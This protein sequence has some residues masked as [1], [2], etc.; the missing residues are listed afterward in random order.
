[1]EWLEVDYATPVVPAMVQVYET[2]HPGA[3]VCVTVFGPDGAEV[4]AWL[5][6]DP[7]PATTA[8]GVSTVPLAV[9]FKISRVRL[10]LD[11]SKVPG[12]NEVD[13]VGL[14]DQAG[15]LQWAC[16]ARASSTYASNLSGGHPSSASS[17]ANPASSQTLVPPWGDFAI[18]N[19]SNFA[20][21]PETNRSAEAHGWPVLAF[22]GER[23][24]SA[25][26]PW[27]PV[28]PIHPIWRG[29]LID[30]LFYAVAAWL[31]LWLLTRPRRFVQE[32]SRMKRGCCVACGYDLGFDFLAGCP[33]CGW[34][35]DA[36]ISH[37]P[38]TQSTAHENPG[39][40][41]ER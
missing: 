11:S 5:G 31:L 18:S 8:S 1:M 14:V 32:L 3:L 19:A 29:L 20:R 36:R 40:G 21:A 9:K 37:I 27:K 23:R 10:Y 2:Y 22:W 30:A 41:E 7:T 26:V 24:A 25:N 12:W 17:T 34:R 15:H 16:D 39:N 38:P 4:D 13:A 35:R 33:E 28:L 6:T